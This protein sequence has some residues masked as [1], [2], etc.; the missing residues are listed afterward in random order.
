MNNNVP[1]YTAVAVYVPES[2]VII[3][4]GFGKCVLNSVFIE[5]NR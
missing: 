2:K 4:Y 3:N 1:N 5:T